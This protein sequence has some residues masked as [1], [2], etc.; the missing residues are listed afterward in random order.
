MVMGLLA[1]VMSAK[2][3]DLWSCKKLGWGGEL[4]EARLRR[5][6]RKH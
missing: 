4:Q 6:A 2:Q 3:F 1:G 5:G